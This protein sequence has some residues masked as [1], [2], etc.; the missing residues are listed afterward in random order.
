MESVEEIRRKQELEFIASL[1]ADQEKVYSVV[2][3]S[4]LLPLSTSIPIE[5]Q[6]QN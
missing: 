3:L 2:H 5:T 1:K 4:L 6:V